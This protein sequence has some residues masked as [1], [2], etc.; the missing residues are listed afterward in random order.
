V[1]HDEF[2]VA[3]KRT[4]PVIFLVSDQMKLTQLN[5]HPVLIVVHEK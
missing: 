2:I 1:I 3:G 4:S 5:V